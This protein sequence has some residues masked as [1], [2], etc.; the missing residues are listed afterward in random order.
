MNVKRMSGKG[1]NGHARALYAPAL[2]LAALCLAACG[3]DRK[4]AGA[5]PV[6]V[7]A[8]TA[9]VM[10]IPLEVRSIGTVEA[11]NTVTVR[12]RVG[13]EIK[14][15]FFE[16]GQ[17][18]RRGDMLFLIDPAPCQAALDAARA[19]LTRDSV[20]WVNARETVRRYTELVR[21]EYI[22]AQ[23]F[24]DMQAQERQL[25]AAVQAARANLDNAV[26]NLQFCS[27]RSP[28]DGRTGLRKVDR[29]NIVRANESELVV[30][31]QVQPIYVTFTIPE[32][33]LA[34]IREQS[35]SGAL[36]VRVSIPDDGERLYDGKLSFLDNTVDEATGTLRLK[37]EFD[38]RELSLWPGQFVDTRL[39]L[40]TLT[41]VTAVPSQAVQPGQN[42]SY[43][44]VVRP[45]MSV[46]SRNVRVSYDRDNLSVIESGLQPGDIVITD[47][48]LRL[49]P[50]SVVQFR[51]GLGAGADSSGS[52]SA[53]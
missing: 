3:G 28:L 43:V 24:D 15:V 22:T 45:D 31:N 4:P 25:G 49:R 42:G 16:E 13:G 40:K 29:G 47:G 10:D 50:G 19:Q 38:N 12:A 21:K 33:H 20:A 27:V 46:E 6:P 8:D 14:Q 36:A 35:A 26:L 23:Q 1:S 41:G 9:R 37:A 30:I 17:D 53:R 2:C 51:S 11:Y 34:D 48:Q 39:E 44:F 7:L 32:R 52:R 18:V 5:P